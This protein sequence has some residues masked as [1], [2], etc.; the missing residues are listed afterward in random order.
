MNAGTRER[1][2]SYSFI[3]LIDCPTHFSQDKVLL[4]LGR[5]NFIFNQNETTKL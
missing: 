2:R 5:Q 1:I 3:L 4:T